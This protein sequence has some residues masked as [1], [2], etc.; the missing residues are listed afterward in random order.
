MSVLFVVSGCIF[1]VDPGQEKSDSNSSTDVTDTMMSDVEVGGGDV[2]DGREAGDVAEMDADTRVPDGGETGVVPP[3]E[4]PCHVGTSGPVGE[5]ETLHFGVLL[6]VSEG[7]RG[8]SWLGGNP[9][10]L[11]QAIDMAVEHVN[12][13]TPF[14]DRPVGAIHCELT[15]SSGGAE[16]AVE[17]LEQSGVQAVIGPGVSSRAASTVRA[18]VDNGM[19]T[20]LPSNPSAE[21]GSLLVE[22]RD[23]LDDELVFRTIPDETKQR[24][25]LKTLT[26]Y[27]YE[28]EAEGVGGGLVGEEFAF[29]TS[30]LVSEEAPVA[31][32]FAATLEQFVAEEF[33]LTL[34]FEHPGLDGSDGSFIDWAAV[35]MR[36]K[37]DLLLLAGRGE[38]WRLLGT[39][40]ERQAQ[41]MVESSLFLA[42]QRSRRENIARQF[43]E[44]FEDTELPDVRGTSLGAP[45]EEVY[46]PYQEFID[47][48]L[49][50]EGKNSRPRGPFAPS[51]YD[52][53][54]MV[55]LS[56]VTADSYDG[57]AIGEKFDLL[58]TYDDASYD[59]P[60][61][62][63][64]PVVENLREGQPVGVNGASGPWKFDESGQRENA[65]IVLW[66]LTEGDGKLY[67]E[68]NDLL[69]SVDTDPEKSTEFNEG[70]ATCEKIGFQ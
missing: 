41:E 18:L 6:P 50:Q 70:A 12:E 3:N 1:A 43:G 67:L 26:E 65:A 34:R 14:E 21:M 27:H 37:I 17:L 58:A 60:G 30:R 42:H 68:S 66:C 25:I 11:R 22:Q 55:A 51:A 57:A 4:E 45:D 63:L 19:L 44:I 69:S 36:R 61:N 52:A 62:P 10:E 24:P 32:E 15:S 53:S 28:R 9:S 38:I 49:Q 54:V 7:A 59:F 47:S 23:K 46:E 8:G 2:A 29:A 40:A 31:S 20:V 13:Q 5:S 35:S 16:E 48:W 39:L 56:L 33:Q 64:N